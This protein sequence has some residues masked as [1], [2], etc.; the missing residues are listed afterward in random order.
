[1]GCATKI[2]NGGPFVVCN[3]DGKNMLNNPIYNDGE[4]CRYIVFHLLKLYVFSAC[5]GGRKCSSSLCSNCIKKANKLSKFS[6][7]H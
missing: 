2:C 7:S 3:Y 1:M 6:K 5:E 4:T